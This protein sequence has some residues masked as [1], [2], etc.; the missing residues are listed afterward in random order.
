MIASFETEF[1]PISSVSVCPGKP[2]RER[3][4]TLRLARSKAALAC[5]ATYRSVAIEESRVSRY[6]FP[7]KRIGRAKWPH[8]RVAPRLDADWK[9]CD[10]EADRRK[11]E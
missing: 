5:I 10:R 6:T 1:V 2:T 8:R 7:W 11:S 4:R 9:Q 3:S